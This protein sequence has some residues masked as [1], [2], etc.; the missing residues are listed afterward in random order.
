MS[1]DH[2]NYIRYKA[3]KHEIDHFNQFCHLGTVEVCLK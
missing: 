1:Q 3:F 2:V